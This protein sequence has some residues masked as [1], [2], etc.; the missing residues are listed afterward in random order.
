LI[1]R[2]SAKRN[3][4]SSQWIVSQC[5]SQI[6]SALIDSVYSLNKHAFADADIFGLKSLGSSRQRIHRL[7]LFLP[8][9]KYFRATNIAQIHKDQSE[10]NISPTGNF[11]ISSFLLYATGVKCCSDTTH[12]LYVEVHQHKHTCD[13]NNNNNNKGLSI[14]ANPRQTLRV[15]STFRTGA[16]T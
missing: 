11:S 5:E 6:R 8:L 4:V 10:K 16:G 7:R 9:L 14:L 1:A 13:N 15:L 12:V 3:F 2:S